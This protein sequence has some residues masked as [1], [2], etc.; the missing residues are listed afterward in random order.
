MQHYFF[1]CILFFIGLTCVAQP[2]RYSS[3]DP[4]HPI[5]FGGSYVVYQTDTISLGPTSFFIDGQLSDAEAA[6]YPFVFNSVNEAV[7]HLTDG[8][9]VSPMTLYLA[10]YVYWIDDPDDP[11]IRVPQEGRTPYGLIVACEWLRFEGL[12][13]DPRNVVLAANRGQTIGAKG[14]FTLFKFIGQGTSSENVTFG[15]YC[16]VDLEFPLKPSLNREKRASAIVQAQLIHCNGDKIVARNTRFISRLNLC[17][18][19]GGK[20]VLFDRCHFESTDD[21]LCGTGVYLNSTLDFYSSKPFYW[22]TGTGAVFLN[23]DIRSFTRGPQYFTKA[24]GQV[25]VV[26]T[27]ITAD[28]MTYLGW[29]DEPPPQARNYQSQVSL[30]GKPVQIDP[31]HPSNTVDMREQALLRAYRFTHDGAV[32]YNI[33]NLLRGIDDWDPMQQ[34]ARVQAAEQAEGKPLT[35]LP[36][37]LLLAPAEASLE[38]GKDKVLLTARA[39]RFGNYDATGETIAWRVAPEDAAFVQLRVGADG[40]TCEVIPTNQEDAPRQVLVMAA[41]PAGLEAASVVTVAPP[42]LAAPA[43]RTSPRFS[44]VSNGQLAVDYR[45]DT[46]FEDRSQVTW[47]RCTDAQG[48]D[49]IPVAV[50]R[51][52]Q[53]LRQYELMPGD[54]G[55]F[56]KVAVAPQHLR[57]HAGAPVEIITKKPITA[58]QVTADHN[59]VATDFQHLP[60]QNQPEVIPGFWTLC[61]FDTTG[62]NPNQERDAWW[63]GE[64]QDGAAGVRGLGQGRSASLFYTPTD[65]AHEDMKLTLTVA[66]YKSAGQGFSV[67]PLY[68]DVLIKFDANTRSGYA[69]RFIRTTKYH[70]AVDAVLVKYERGTATAISDPVSTSCYRTPCR[71]SL[72]VKDGKLIA[73]AETEAEVHDDR[74]EVAREVNLAVG[75][76]ES[77]WGGFGIQYN[78]GAPTVIQELRAEWE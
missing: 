26:D 35:Q 29:Q 6:S 60:T 75:I 53:P 37:Q 20:R 23:C 7:E 46:P 22:T 58:K 21:A 3:L 1:F 33:Y 12:T 36:V 68:M 19:V 13:D 27:R 30:N 2:T 49:P 44:R 32:V 5:Q 78:G 14:N 63:Y 54:V 65:E 66:P 24:R 18:F 56:L 42:V 11:A 72:E 41:T 47:Y 55:Y 25:A 69:L 59:V 48:S 70:D 16:N 52:D 57:S 67:A 17:P 15:N 9:E 61:H 4:E 45:L 50:S 34:K 71:I 51:F 39:M 76:P 62:E 73:H 38:T 31:E 64:G 40:Q 28:G 10:P 74:P 77:A 43:F 8:T